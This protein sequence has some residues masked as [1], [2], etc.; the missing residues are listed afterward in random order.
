MERTLREWLRAEPY[1]LALSAGFFGFFAHLGVLSVLERE[2]LR[3]RR[4]YGASAGAL[5]AGL[6]GAGV[7]TERMQDELVAL[8]RADFWDPWPGPGLLRGKLFRQRLDA[9]LDGRAFADCHT[10]VGISVFDLAKR[11]T[12][13]LRT[14]AI[15]PAIHASCAL[16]GMFHPVR[17]GDRIY[18][19]GGVL[20]RP[21]LEGA[22]PGERILSHFLASKSPWSKGVQARHPP[23]RANSITLLIEGLPRVHPFALPRGRDAY[24]SAV[25]ATAEAL[26]RAV[27]S[28]VSRVVA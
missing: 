18:V 3:P 16:P 22:E 19:D 10:P 4:L 20:D 6:W 26:N 2:G 7:T 13:V 9:L 27:L 1:S 15:A 23:V 14:G 28:G 21:A 17:V 12:S 11:R 24:H 8:K 5:V 25:R